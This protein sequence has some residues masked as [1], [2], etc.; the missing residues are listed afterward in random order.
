MHNLNTTA[1]TRSPK[2][3]STWQKACNSFKKYWR[4]EGEDANFF[5]IYATEFKDQSFTSQLKDFGTL[6][7]SCSN[8]CFN[9]ELWMEN[10]TSFEKMMPSD[11]KP[12]DVPWELKKWINEIKRKPLSWEKACNSFKKYW[13]HEDNDVS[14]FDLYATEF[15]GQ[16][17]T[18][19]LETSD[20]C[21]GELKVSFK[22]GAFHMELVNDDQVATYE[23][24]KMLR[25]PQVED[26]KTWHTFATKLRHIA[27]SLK[28]TNF[29]GDDGEYNKFQVTDDAITVWVNEKPEVKLII[30][31]Y[32]T[33]V[34]MDLHNNDDKRLVQ[35]FNGDIPADR[36]GCEASYFLRKNSE[37]CS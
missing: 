20:Y 15:N 30:T 29:I 16:S 33:T 8:G 35:P 22:D 2:P 7:C 17:F 4:H 23:L 25:D 1:A 21:H 5:D 11:V 24:S 6:T 12:Y 32:N 36:T 27:K 14:F 31:V 9:M 26:M 18:S 28:K 19:R 34:W 3:L 37:L 10:G 13:R